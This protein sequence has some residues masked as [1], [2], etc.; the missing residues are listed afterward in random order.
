MF[1]WRG[2]IYPLCG[3]EER[4]LPKSHVSLRGLIM[5]DAEWP[6]A[7]GRDAC[8][9]VNV[10]PSRTLSRKCCIVVSSR[11]QGRTE[12]RRSQC[13]HQY[14]V[15]RGQKKPWNLSSHSGPQG[16]L[17]SVAA[18]EAQRSRDSSSSSVIH[19]FLSFS[20]SLSFTAFLPFSF[21]LWL[22]PSL[23]SRFLQ[24]QYC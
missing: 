14:F 24:R 12:S 4:L 11:G 13:Q 22:L 9:P 15:E 19:S 23:L 20:P 2:Y 21:L 17:A 6:L 8:I 16:F 1:L 7:H 3:D 18:K 5:E 10:A